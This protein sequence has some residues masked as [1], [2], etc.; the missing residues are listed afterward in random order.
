MEQQDKQNQAQTAHLEG[1]LKGY[2]NNLV[3]ESIR[4]RYFYLS[5]TI[6]FTYGDADCK[7]IDGQ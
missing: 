1:Q 6:H 7:Q 2:K 3:K 4:V 5:H